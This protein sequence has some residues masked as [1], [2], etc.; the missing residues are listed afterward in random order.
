MGRLTNSTVRSALAIILGLVL[1]LWPE[2]AIYYLVITI[3]ILFILPGIF[4]LLAYFTRDKDVENPRTFP[5]EAAGSIL[6]GALLVI[7]PNFFVN[8]L[9]YLLGIL[10]LIGCIQQLVSLIRARKWAFVSWV[11]YIIPVLLILVGIIILSNPFT[12]VSSTF[13][14]FGVACI[15]YGISELINAYRFRKRNEFTDITDVTDV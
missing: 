12:V 5:L 2:V 3:G 14:V 15:V 1:V 10:L 7:I 4:A 6:F 8:T 13:I 9:M 11:F